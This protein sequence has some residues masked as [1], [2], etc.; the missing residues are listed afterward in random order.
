MHIHKQTHHVIVLLF[1]H[2][3][4]AFWRDKLVYIICPGLVMFGS[5]YWLW[6]L[7]LF[8]QNER[9]SF[10]VISQNII[11]MLRFTSLTHLLLMQAMITL[12]I[13]QNYN[14]IRNIKTNSLFTWVFD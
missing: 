6:P 1:L 13:I 3:V 4:F 2:G 8:Q 11:Q 10:Q 9:I 12:Q 14:A 7:S 5:F